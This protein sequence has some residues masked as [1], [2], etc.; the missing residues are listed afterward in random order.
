MGGK[1]QLIGDLFDNQLRQVLFINPRLLIN[2]KTQI[3][4][5][6]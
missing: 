1:L 6:N 5:N 2:L 4:S 3:N